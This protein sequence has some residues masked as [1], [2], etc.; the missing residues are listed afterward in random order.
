[1]ALPSTQTQGGFQNEEP[2]KYGPNEGANRTPEKELSDM[3][4]ANLSD[5]E[6]KT[7]VVRMLKGI[8]EYSKNIREEMQALLRE[9]RKNP[10]ETNSEG[11]ETRIQTN[12]L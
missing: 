1:M 3:G 2:K 12:N 5:T 7:L 11:K 6:Y 4:E 8:T 9:I 10:K